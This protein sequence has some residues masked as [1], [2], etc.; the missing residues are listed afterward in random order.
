MRNPRLPFRPARLAAGLLVCAGLALL[1]ACSSSPPPEQSKPAS[2]ARKPEPVKVT[3]FYASPGEV[4]RGEEITICY[5]VENADA[6]SI[7]PNVRAIKPGYNRCFSF[8]PSKSGTYKL[9]A[10]G[11]GGE[12]SAELSIRVRQPAAPA[13]KAMIGTFVASAKSVPGAGRVT[14]CYSVDGAESVAIDPPVRELDPV[15]K[16]FIV[17]ME[18]TTTFTLTATAPGGRKEQKQI[19]VQVR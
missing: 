17:K 10:T 11:P 1:A 7:E 16:C 9:I 5:G 3:R 13:R 2:A 12:D 19:T 6:V 8:A 15:S 14:L 4:T 18:E